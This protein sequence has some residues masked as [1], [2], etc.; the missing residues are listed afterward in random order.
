MSPGV[1]LHEIGQ[2][3]QIF[4]WVSAINLTITTKG[5]VNQTRGSHLENI[6]RAQQLCIKPTGL[7]VNSCFKLTQDH[8]CY[9]PQ[10][11]WGEVIFLRMSVI[12]FTGGC[13]PQC[14][15]GYNPPEQTPTP[16]RHPPAR[17]TVCWEIRATR[18]R[19][20]SY[21]NAYLFLGEIFFSRSIPFV[22]PDWRFFGVTKVGVNASE[23]LQQKGVHPF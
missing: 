16:S 4:A 19:C 11:S 20:T 10:R 17:C 21:W 5:L 15:L 13:L 1:V 14:M 7:L 18:E 9:R 2:L 12:L 23:A 6:Q 22:L 8:I 3:R